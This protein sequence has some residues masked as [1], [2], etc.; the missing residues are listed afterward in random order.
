MVRGVW[1]GDTIVLHLHLPGHSMTE[2]EEPAARANA[3]SPGELIARRVCELTEVALRRSPQSHTTLPILAAT[4]EL[5]NESVTRSADRER[6]ACRA[7]CSAC[8]HLAVSITAP[9][10][11]WMARRLRETRPADELAE[12]LG[13]IVATSQRGSHLTI[14]ER[15]QERVPC[16]LLTVDGACSIHSFRPIGC[17][18]WTSFSR[19]DCDRALAEGEPG[20]SG[21]MDRAVWEAAGGVTDGLERAMR[22]A[23]VDSGHYELHGAL[24]TALETQDSE[25]KWA[26]HEPVFIHC[27]RVRSAKLAGSGG[28]TSGKPGGKSGDG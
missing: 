14:E 2:R 27:R 11:L 10:A 22:S 13:R 5:L 24:R 8:C 26:D 12:V 4:V 23:G 19:A 1:V 6:C 28:E 18:G 7:G 16:A 9:E 21:P 17:R 20:H 3:Q 15:A 25:Q